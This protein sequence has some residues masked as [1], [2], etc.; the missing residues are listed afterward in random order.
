MRAPS[1]LLERAR[2]VPPRQPR[3]HPR[4]YRNHQDRVLSDAVTTSIARAEPFE[5]DFLTGLLPLPRHGAAVE[6]GSGRN[7]HP[8]G[9]GLAA[10]GDRRPRS[11][12][13]GRHPL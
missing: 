4:A 9:R 11:A 7:Q 1:A 8:P 5:D 13:L 2:A 12:P 3:Q 10:G 6:A